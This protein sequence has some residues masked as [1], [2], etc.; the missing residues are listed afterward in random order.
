MSSE[1]TINLSVTLYEEGEKKLIAAFN[2]KSLPFSVSSIIHLLSRQTFLTFGV[3]TRTL[4]QTFKL[5]RQGLRWY[6]P[7]KLDQ[8][9]RY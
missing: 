7:I 8:T 5:W 4:W 2:G 3:V 1:K 9:R 6:T